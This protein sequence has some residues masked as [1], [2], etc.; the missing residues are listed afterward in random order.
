M[1]QYRYDYY[2]YCQH[3]EFILVKFCEDA[4][5][6]AR[7]DRHQTRQT[8][9]GAIVQAPSLDTT[10]V[11]LRAVETNLCVSEPSIVLTGEVDHSIYSLSTI[12]HIIVRLVV[13]YACALKILTLTRSST[14]APDTEETRLVPSSVPRHFLQNILTHLQQWLRPRIC[15]GS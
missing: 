1:C 7:V 6:L 11:S 14:M 8:T 3:Q 2:G 12:I 10:T 15:P 5:S 9:E 4:V 13:L